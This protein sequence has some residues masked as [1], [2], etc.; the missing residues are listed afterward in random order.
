[1]SE[2]NGVERR[3][4]LVAIASHMI[5]RGKENTERFRPRVAE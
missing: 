5:R 4:E 2:E 3:P 1:M